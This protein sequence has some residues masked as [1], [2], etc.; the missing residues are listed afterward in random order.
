MITNFENITYDVSSVEEEAAKFLARHLNKYSKGKRNSIKSSALSKILLKKNKNWKISDA[1]LRKLINLIRHNG[2]SN[3]LLA[4]SKGYFVSGS[5]KE[6]QLYL[7]S[8]DERANEINK[9]RETLLTQAVKKFRLPKVK[10]VTR[11]KK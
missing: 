1:R 3:C 10:K 8:L 9:I 7:Q 2:W 5:K 4:T 11:C 6:V